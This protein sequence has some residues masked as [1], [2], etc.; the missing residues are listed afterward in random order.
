MLQPRIFEEFSGNVNDL[1]PAA[2]KYTFLVGAGIS[3]NPPSNLPSARYIVKILLNSCLPPKELKD[4]P[5][6]KLR[7]EKIV[8]LIQ[9]YWDNEL[10][11]LDYFDLVK[12]P[13]VI[14]FLLANAIINGYYVVTTNF[15][16]LIEYALLKLITEEF[17][18][19][20]I[21][22]ITR[23]D[24]LKFNDPKTMFGEGKYPLYKIHGAKR[25]VITNVKTTESLVTTMTALSKDRLEG[26][27]FAIEPYKK[28]AFKNL[29]KG[30]TLIVMGYSGS[31]DFDI[32][33]ILKE[34]P[35]INH[36]IWIEHSHGGEPDIS[37]V[38]QVKIFEN[39]TFKT[40]SDRLLVEIRSDSFF[41]VYKIKVNTF[42]FIKNFLWNQF[43]SGNLIPELNISEKPI[44]KPT[45]ENW[46]R[47]LFENV[48]L[49]LKYLIAGGIHS[50]L[51]DFNRQEICYEKGL[52]LAEKKNNQH[53]KAIFLSKLGR[54]KKTRGDFNQ[55]QEL[56]EESFQI[57]K[58]LGIV[59][60]ANFNDLALINWE[61]GHSEKALNFLETAIKMVEKRKNLHLKANYLSNISEIYRTLGK[62]DIAYE[63]LKEAL[64]IVENLG[65]F[66][67]K[68]NILSQIG[69]CYAS[70]KK[71][72]LAIKNFQEALRIAEK[73]GNLKLKMGPL[74]NI[75]GV[76]L[77]QGIYDKAL[78]FFNQ[79][80][81][82]SEKVGDKN[83]KV[84]ILNNIGYLL[85]KKGNETKAY[86]IF[87]E[88]LKISES[89]DSKRLILKCLVNLA[90]IYGIR[91]GKDKEIEILQK[92]LKIAENIGDQ[93]A[94]ER[95]KK[96]IEISRFRSSEIW[97]K[98]ETLN[99]EGLNFLEQGEFDKA[100]DKFE[101]VLTL[102]EDSRDIF[103]I[104][105]IINNIA[106][107]YLQKKDYDKAIENFEKSLQIADKDGVI[108][109]KASILNNL[110]RVMTET[111]KY[112]KAIKYLNEAL[113][114]EKQRHDKEKIALVLI[115]L[116]K[117]SF[118]KGSFQDALEKF[119]EARQILISLGKKVDQ[120]ERNIEELK[121][122]NNPKLVIYNF[123][124]RAE[125]FLNEGKYELA[126]ENLM[127]GLDLTE[128]HNL[129]EDKLSLLNL[130]G[131]VYVRKGDY[132]TG[133]KH[134]EEVLPKLKTNGREKK[135]A[136]CLLN[137]GATYHA[138]GRNEIALKH[139]DEGLAILKGLGDTD[140][141]KKHEQLYSLLKS[142]LAE[143]IDTSVF[144]DMYN[145]LFNI[146]KNNYNQGNYEQALQF[147]KKALEI[148]EKDK[149]DLETELIYQ[150][151]G[152]TY[153][154]LK[155][156][157]LALENYENAMMFASKAN[158]PNR[159]PL[160]LK[161]IGD[162]LIERGN[163]DEAFNKYEEA[164]NLAYEHSS[165]AIIVVVVIALM[166]WYKDQGQFDEVLNRLD[167]ISAIA[168]KIE[169][170]SL[171]ATLFLFKGDFEDIQGNFEKAYEMYENALEIY[172]KLQDSKFQEGIYE[173]INYLRRKV[174]EPELVAAEEEEIAMAIVAKGDKEL[175]IKI[176]K[177]VALIYKKI[178]AL[179]KQKEI[180]EKIK[181][182]D[183][184]YKNI[185]SQ[186]DKF[187][188]LYERG[189]SF[190][191]DGENVKALGLYKQAYAI[192]ERTGDVDNKISINIEMGGSYKS[193][194][195]YNS[196]D[197]R[198]KEALRLSEMISRDS[199]IA[200]ILSLIGHIYQLKYD[201]QNA[202]RFMEKSLNL[203]KKL[204][205]SKSVEIIQEEI[206]Q[207]QSNNIKMGE[208]AYLDLQ[209]GNF[210]DA[211]QKF[212]KMKEIH[213][214]E[215][216][217]KDLIIDLNNL[218]ITYV[219][220]GDIEKGLDY[221][222]Q[223]LEKADEFHD[224]DVKGRILINTWNLYID[225]G[226]K[227]EGL[228]QLD[229]VLS[230]LDKKQDLR[231]K[232]VVL[233]KSGLYFWNENDLDKALKQFKEALEIAKKLEN[234]REI[235]VI[236]ENIG[237]LYGER[238]QIDQAIEKF[239]E[240]LFYVK[241]TEDL[242]LQATFMARIGRFYKKKF[243]NTD[244][245]IKYLQEAVQLFLKVKNLENAGFLLKELGQIHE[246]QNEKIKALKF[247][248]ESLNIFKQID[249]KDEINQISS[250]IRELDGI[251]EE[252]AKDISFL[253]KN[254][255]DFFLKGNYNIAL[256]KY[257]EILRI[258][259]K[260]KINLRRKVSI[261]NN[262][263]GIYSAQNE[264]QNAIKFFRLALESA[265]KIGDFTFIES[266]L[267]NIGIIYNELGDI[268]NAIKNWDEA[269]KYSKDLK[270]FKKQGHYFLHIGELYEKQGNREKTLEYYENSSKVYEL[271]G[272][273]KDQLAAMVKIG[274]FYIQNR[275]KLED[276]EKVIEIFENSLK[277]AEEIG[278]EDIINKIKPFI[279]KYKEINGY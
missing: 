152:M 10:E 5:I 175:A 7:F 114:I 87:Q 105:T 46:V 256:E 63:K 250:K 183:G 228:K 52:K 206:N 187:K 95:I 276:F 34:I 54:I 237:Q 110:G 172:E 72:D 56:Y 44:K 155:I 39:L 140:T 272:Y 245:A 65:G 230:F 270:D 107:T 184:I 33:P 271:Y 137:I 37:L 41:D 53:Y 262:M 108:D 246:E 212:E 13:N 1:F 179:R 75:A 112:E 214:K 234:K 173:K 76:Y 84:V 247:Y 157:N 203:Y 221:L 40:D 111:R 101:K 3:M 279:D 66:G 189:V 207:L 182:I 190:S 62:I 210:D 131:L 199:D 2:D 205:D 235:S 249:E 117:I 252:K 61:L 104:I 258:D 49:E 16:Y 170:E 11:F 145:H 45:F 165:E 163:Y 12:D 74:N 89:M 48:N 30:R 119:K 236:L 168:D 88:A 55:A 132:D 192:V 174:K 211:L 98:V 213:V 217:K 265:K 254:A 32:S 64:K 167:N 233:N 232:C 86:Q 6:E 269:M 9:D 160:Y 248:R 79:S 156:D 67:L 219:R 218:G 133:L 273:K 241:Q 35:F 14:H 43:L 208:S 244:I 113:L 264:K 109:W 227:E 90:P 57:S 130:V 102:I 191:K 178:G 278:D 94:I 261:L 243:E 71:F 216:N 158:H 142:Q 161:N 51:N 253:I 20:I 277:L 176:L 81:T 36:L 125:S 25:N 195:E 149:N 181:D 144:S 80:L 143:K 166:R 153:H 73:L 225:S 150:W 202:V 96:N 215:N 267:Y 186:R 77:R 92:A 60:S 268:D 50:D 194:G 28:P 38:N 231:L 220:K 115:N 58:K 69:M 70:E 59:T 188:D 259:D 164:S 82:I 148:A 68:H 78:E 196:A 209:K 100:L 204:G 27:T 198:Y 154:S 24:Y 266:I 263:G 29:M 93:E 120:I 251:I 180:E 91:E 17:H 146:A 177:N 116:A 83:L 97:L 257:Q 223:A 124:K 19:N 193:L 121:K 274:L 147:F 4:I 151:I 22:I 171:K 224:P 255:E 99:N 31:D 85:L 238:N 141:I 123:Q 118:E 126:L 47:P 26:E 23:E 162:I 275:K 129:Q 200:L 128:K 239:Q 240:S 42:E 127:K 134:L 169:D 122:M 106:Q 135:Y 242:S 185:V 103:Y 159:V 21:P 18:A 197:E 201:L 226:R 136:I 138:Q 15:D 139:M 222:E 8:E 229:E 260:D